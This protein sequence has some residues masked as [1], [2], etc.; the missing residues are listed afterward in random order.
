MAR[1]SLAGSVW[2]RSASFAT[3]LLPGCCVRR[4][5]SPV[6]TSPFRPTLKVTRAWSPIASAASRYSHART[7]GGN[8]G[9]T[10]PRRWGS[11]K[12]DELLGQVAHQLGVAGI[13]VQ[14]PLSVGQLD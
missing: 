10:G 1:L 11:I 13:G 12:R 3:E 8:R 9:W 14:W 4:L 2:R 6:V 5:S 7:V